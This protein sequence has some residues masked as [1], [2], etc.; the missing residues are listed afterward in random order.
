MSY[1]YVSDNESLGTIFIRIILVGLI[2]GCVFYCST[3]KTKTDKLNV[4]VKCDTT[5]T[6]NGIKYTTKQINDSTI[7]FTFKKIE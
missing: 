1:I 6:L 3:P 5:Y 2:L 4:D 7:T